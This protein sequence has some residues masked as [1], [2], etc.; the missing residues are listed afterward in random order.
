MKI[1]L[2]SIIFLATFSV[3]AQTVSLA[4]SVARGKTIYEGQC[5]SC[6]MAEGEGLESVYPSLTKSDNLKDKNRLAK[7]VLKGQRGTIKVKGVDYSGEM[8]GF[9]M[10]DQEVADVLNFIRNSWGNKNAEIRPGEIQPAL[11]METKGYQPY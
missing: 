4:Q 7:I 10:N 9:A 11:K 1:L 2:V 5:M 8:I 3:R 6:H